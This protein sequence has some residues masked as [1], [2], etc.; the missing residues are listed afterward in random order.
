MTGKRRIEPR[1]DPL[2]GDLEAQERRA[3][4]HRCSLPRNFDDF[5]HDFKLKVEEDHYRRRLKWKWGFKPGDERLRSL[6][7]KVSEGEVVFGEKVDVDD[8][9][10]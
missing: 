3:Y 2:A 10:S 6:G 7:G 4:E 9:E 5:D 8:D 1:V